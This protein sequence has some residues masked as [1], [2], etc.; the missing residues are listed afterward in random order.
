M[1]VDVEYKNQNLIV[2]YINNKGNIMLKYYPWKNC[3]KFIQTS[4][5]D[6]ER[7]GKYVSW[8]GKS[9]KSIY[10][11]FPNRYAI[12]DF[13]DSLPKEEQDEKDEE[14]NEWQSLRLIAPKYLDH[15]LKKL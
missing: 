13:I 11:K 15:M 1:I 6:E 8:N 2:S 5:D 9:V 4:D 12:Y 7:S 14:K 10:T 3:T